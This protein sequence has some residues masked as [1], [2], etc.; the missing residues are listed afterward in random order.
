MFDLDHWQEIAAALAKNRLRTF[1][2][3]FGVFWGI[4]LLVVLL[5]SGN[6]LSNGVLSGFAGSATNSFF[7]W[8][9]RTSKPYAG[10]PAGRA[11]EFTNEDTAALVQQV[12]EAQVVAPRLQL[13]GHRGSATARRAGETGSFSVMGDHPEIFQ[14]QSMILDRGRLLNRYDVEEKRKVAVIGTRVQEVLFEKD[15]DPVGDAIEING[16][17]FKV[18]GVFRT[19]QTGNQA[20][21]DLQT[22]YVPFSTF[23]QAFNA[24]NQVHWYAVTAAPG[25]RASVVEERVLDI[26]RSRHKVASDDRRGIGHFNLEEE[27]AKIQGLFTGIQLLMWIV[28]LGT[29]SAGAIGVSNIMLI[30]VRERTREIGIRRAIGARPRSVIGQIVLEAVILTALA[31]LLGLA[32]GVG[33]MELVSGQLAGGGGGD[34]GRSMFQNPGVTLGDALQALAVLIAAGTIAGLIPAQRAVAVSP[35]VALRSE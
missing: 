9:M 3:A 2:T 15:E 25:H 14:I 21:R 1:L 5:G 23:Q 27:F 11:V 7:V 16:V 10:L 33:V 24:A 28:G 29:L 18:V 31:G 22:I 8:G 6:G 30:V 19:R 32:A 4:F 20:E 12:T 35:V 17:W 34:G 13:G 26:L